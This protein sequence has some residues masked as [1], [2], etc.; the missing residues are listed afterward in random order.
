M[1]ALDAVRVAP[2]TDPVSQSVPDSI[3]VAEPNQIRTSGIPELHVIG[4]EARKGLVK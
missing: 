4:P 3:V 2:A 1:S